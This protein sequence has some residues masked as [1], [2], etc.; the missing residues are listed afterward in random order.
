MHLS[1]SVC[2]TKKKT[3]ITVTGS[4]EI[5]YLYYVIN[6]RFCREI[7]FVEL[8]I[9]SEKLSGISLKLFESILTMKKI[10]RIVNDMILTIFF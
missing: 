4:I 3:T 9:N 1:Q 7:R 8:F 5:G 6:S 10:I 2:K